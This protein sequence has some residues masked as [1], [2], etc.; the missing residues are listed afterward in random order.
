MEGVA[1]LRKSLGLSKVCA[2]FVL[3][4]LIVQHLHGGMS[5]Y[6]HWTRGA[7]VLLER[8]SLPVLSFVIHT[9]FWRCCEALF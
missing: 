3:L 4:I 6:Q 1:E 9:H 5:V 8:L 2:Y 7:A